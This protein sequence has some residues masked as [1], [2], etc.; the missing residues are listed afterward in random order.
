MKVK[1]KMKMKMK[2]KMTMKVEQLFTV[3]KMVIQKNEWKGKRKV[4]WSNLV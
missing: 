2:I 3:H 4:K 1:M